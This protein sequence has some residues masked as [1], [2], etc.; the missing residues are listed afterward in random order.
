MYTKFVVL[1]LMPLLITIQLFAN[2][3][4]ST[5][6]TATLLS[7]VATIIIVDLMWF[8][9]DPIVVAMIQLVTIDLTINMM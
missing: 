9:F 2:R 1:L 6:M 8:D 4:F 5:L 7:L 3:L